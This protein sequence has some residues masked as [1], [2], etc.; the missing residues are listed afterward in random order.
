MCDYIYF[1]SK[2]DESNLT[3]NSIICFIVSIRYSSLHNRAIKK[4]NLIYNSL[5]L[6]FLWNQEI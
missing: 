6:F 2:V 5:I 3:Y 4:S 1:L